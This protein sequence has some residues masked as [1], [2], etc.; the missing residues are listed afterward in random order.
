MLRDLVPYALSSGDA[1]IIM[2]MHH[3]FEDSSDVDVS[4]TTPLPTRTR[5]KPALLPRVGVD[6][7]TGHKPMVA[8]QNLYRTAFFWKPLKEG[9]ASLC[10]GA[11][12]LTPI[13]P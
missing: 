4:L 1:N 7:L 2:E 6:L 8:G 9:I 5:L 12:S 11:T 13:R 3:S 10:T